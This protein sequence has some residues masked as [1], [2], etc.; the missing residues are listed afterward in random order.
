MS[1]TMFDA[2][3]LTSDHKPRDTRTVKRLCHEASRRST[4]ISESRP[5]SAANAAVTAAFSAPQEV[6][7]GV[8]RE[9]ASETGG[10]G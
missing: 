1:S 2:A 9:F 5:R 6:K 10:C 3:V 8:D 4:P 7:F